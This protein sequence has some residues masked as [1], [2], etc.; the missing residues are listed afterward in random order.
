MTDDSTR[1]GRRL[2]VRELAEFVAALSAAQTGETRPGP[3]EVYLLGTGPAADACAQRLRE[4]L[5]PFG[6]RVVALDDGRP[7]VRAVSAHRP[8]PWAVW[9]AEELDGLVEDVQA[10]RVAHWAQSAAA[11]PRIRTLH[12]PGS[13][14]IGVIEFDCAAGRLVAK[15]G[16]QD[17]M[18][19]EQEHVLRAHAAGAPIFPAPRGFEARDGVAVRL[20]DAV[21]DGGFVDRVFRRDP[22]GLLRADPAGVPALDGH[23][24]VLTEWYTDTLTE[25]EPQ[26][27][28]YLYTERLHRLPESEACRRVG[29]SVLGAA[30][31]RQAFSRPVVLPDGSASSYAELVAWVRETYPQWRP[32]RS[33]VVHGDIFTSNLMW[34]Q[35]GEPRFIDPRSAWDGAAQAV[36][37]HGD[38]VFDLGTLLHAVS[39][40][41]TLLDAVGRGQEALVSPSVGPDSEGEL[42]ARDLVS[43][44]DCPARAV[45][46]DRAARLMAGWADPGASVRMHLASACSLLGWLKYPKVVRTP[47]IWWAVFLAVVA[48][49]ARARRVH[50]GCDPVFTHDG[51]R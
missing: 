30:A 4:G 21:T 40:M 20:M 50:E 32:L 13:D 43:T 35:A 34:G 31:Y 25:G 19:V 16:P 2:D 48:D 15:V 49:L 12:R 45:Y 33:A 5:V 23:L 44:E 6:F 18:L 42:D 1:R 22:D 51:P 9:D 41:V 47:G 26:V 8:G 38:P 36:A 11:Q 29:E 39:P 24:E 17:V 7:E 37:G 3:T 27:A 28:A 10:E 46:L 14:S